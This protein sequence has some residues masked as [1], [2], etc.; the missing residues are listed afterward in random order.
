MGPFRSTVSS[1][2]N[3]LSMHQESG[4]SERTLCETAFSPTKSQFGSE[5]TF[6][7]RKGTPSERGPLAEL[8]FHAGDDVFH[9]RQVLDELRFGGGKAVNFGFVE[10]G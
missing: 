4:R 10:G 8:G 2:P 7:L 3:S 9:F 6:E 5:L 1:V